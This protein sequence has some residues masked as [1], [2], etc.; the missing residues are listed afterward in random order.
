MQLT[1]HGI[2]TIKEYVKREKQRLG[3]TGFEQETELVMLDS[4]LNYFNKLET[5]FKSIQDILLKEI[6][7]CYNDE[8]YDL[9]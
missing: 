4:V 8:W 9:D 2:N 5:D 6:E 7:T 3:P 1:A